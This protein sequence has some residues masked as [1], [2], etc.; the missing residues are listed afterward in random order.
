MYGIEV[1]EAV[2]TDEVIKTYFVSIDTI[3]IWISKL[4][5]G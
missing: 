3:F 1:L 2:V 4:L 5:M